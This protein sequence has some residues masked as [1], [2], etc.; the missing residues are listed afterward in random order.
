M[1]SVNMGIAVLNLDDRALIYLNRAGHGLFAHQSAQPD[2]ALLSHLMFPPGV[3]LDGLPPEYHGAPLHLDTRLLGYTVYRA[4][5]FAWMF[6]RDITEKARMEALAEAVESTSNIGT[7]FS[8]VRHELGNPINSVK[9]GLGVLR[10]NIDTFPR[11]TVLDYLDRMGSELGRVEALLHSLRTFSMFEQVEPMRVDMREF[12][13]A[14]ATL[15][16]TDLER[17][18]IGFVVTHEAGCAALA[19][20][21]ALQQALLN[22]VANAAD[23]VEGRADPRVSLVARCHD[24]LARVT[25]T[26]NGVGMN[27]E[28]AGAA[29]TPFWTT[30]PHGTGLG[31]VITRKLL[32]KMAGTITID[33]RAGEGT[34]VHL[35]LPVSPKVVFA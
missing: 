29:F 7:I 28:Q 6:F 11:E 21:R 34:K 9:A 3:P 24:G 19:D 1:Q 23:A 27:A 35:S 8:V 16:R 26:D 25:V 31:L 33:S 5:A 15:A 10:A 17:R 20:P 12:F 18:G 14:F 2:F 32:L 30:K 13:E 4:G 22:V